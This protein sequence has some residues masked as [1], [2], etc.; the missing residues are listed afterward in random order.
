MA[1]HESIFVS[2]WYFLLKYCEE[3]ELLILSI[4]QLIIILPL[5]RLI[6]CVFC[7]KR[8]KKGGF[9]WFCPA[10]CITECLG[11]TASKK[12]KN[13]KEANDTASL[14]VGTGVVTVS[15]LA[16][17]AKNTKVKTK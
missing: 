15:G 1:F 13:K 7:V 12:S 5:L 17:Q 14:D 10:I 2:F 11:C 4:P 8:T 16:G 9:K 6:K 3:I